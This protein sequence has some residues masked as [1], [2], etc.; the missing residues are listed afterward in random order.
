MFCQQY[1]YLV[2]SGL[3]GSWEAL[4]DVWNTFVSPLFKIDKQ[5][6]RF[7]R[8]WNST[9]NKLDIL[10]QQNLPKESSMLLKGT[11]WNLC[12]ALVSQGQLEETEELTT[13]WDS[14]LPQLLP[15]PCPDAKPSALSASVKTVLQSLGQAMHEPSQCSVWARHG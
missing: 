14:L 3:R 13:W 4:G 2:A 10:I 7:W 5:I 8:F 12:F 11:A 6:W 9:T 1:L 15:L